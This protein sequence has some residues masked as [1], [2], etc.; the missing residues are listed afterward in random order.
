MRLIKGIKVSIIVSLLTLIAITA[1]SFAKPENKIN[2]V[3]TS[4]IFEKAKKNDNWKL[5]FV[6]GKNAQV[7]FMNVTP[8]TNPSNEIGMETHKFDQVIFIVEGKAKAVLDGKESIVQ[9][10]DMIYVPQGMP[11]NFINLKANKPF[12]IISIYSDTDIPLN[13]VYK[14]KSDASSE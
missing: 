2:A 10:N 1:L 9:A 12:K 7:V 13:A 8:Q 14:K 5:A 3:I 4:Q 6:T 11:H